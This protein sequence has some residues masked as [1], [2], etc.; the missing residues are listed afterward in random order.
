MDT[1]DKPA[2]PL[3]FFFFYDSFPVQPLRRTRAK[4]HVHLP[5]ESN[6]LNMNDKF[7]TEL[8]ARTSLLTPFLFKRCTKRWTWIL[9][10]W[11]DSREIRIRSELNMIDW[12]ELG[13][14]SF[15]KAV[16]ASRRI[17]RTANS[18]VCGRI[19]YP[20]DISHW[21]LSI[22]D[23]GRKSI[24]RESRLSDVGQMHEKNY[25]EFLMSEGKDDGSD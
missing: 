21:N 10:R 5:H 20:S 7:G 1:F 4:L 13:Q 17:V 16:F 24:H 22:P 19:D 2:L 23:T 12:H 9:G 15:R 3:P 6:E 11:N 14:A 8:P 25:V 18:L